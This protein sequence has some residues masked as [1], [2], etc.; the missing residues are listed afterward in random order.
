MRAVYYEKLAEITVSIEAKTAADAEFSEEIDR[1]SLNLGPFMKAA[2]VA[3]AA[4]GSFGSS[5]AMGSVSRGQPWVRVGRPRTR[6]RHRQAPREGL[7]RVAGGR[8][9]T[10]GT[11]AG[12][13]SS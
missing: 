10:G 7:R 8:S 4:R 3:D 5:Y 2:D 12:R 13:S 6:H 11:V 9:D 1:H